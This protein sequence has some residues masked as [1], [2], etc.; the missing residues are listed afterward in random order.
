MLKSN[1]YKDE[2]LRKDEGGPIIGNIDFSQ[3][4]ELDPSLADGHRIIYERQV[5]FELRLEDTNG[6][7]DA[8][9]FEEIGAK[10]LVVGDDSYPSHL[11]IELSCEN[12]LF[13]HFT[14]K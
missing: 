12:D 8:A 11:R 1:Y 7:L 2:E 3:I 13:F 5:P 6:P 9:T 4:E 10:I 14:S